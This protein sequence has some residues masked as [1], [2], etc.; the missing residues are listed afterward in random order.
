MSRDFRD[1]RGGHASPYWVDKDGHA[2]H[3]RK[4]RRLGRR[5]AKEALR[6]GE[7]PEPKYPVETEYFD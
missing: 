2:D 7:E 3:T 6:R 1:Q 4:C 5:R